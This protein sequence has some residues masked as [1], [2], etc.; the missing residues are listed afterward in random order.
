MLPA[1][2]IGQVSWL[3]GQLRFSKN[4]GKCLVMMYS[5]LYDEN[6]SRL[7]IPSMAL[8]LRYS[9]SKNIRIARQQAVYFTTI[10][11]YYIFSYL[12]QMTLPGRQAIKMLAWLYA[13]SYSEF[14]LSLK[15]LYCFIINSVLNQF[16]WDPY[17]TS[18]CIKLDRVSKKFLTFEDFIS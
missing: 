9:I 18:H 2:R 1:G 15:A 10:L 14:E 16:C 8:P 11:N 17:T 6:R 7:L 5:V 3:V 13:G 12:E 4:V